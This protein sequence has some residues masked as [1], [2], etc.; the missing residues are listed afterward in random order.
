MYTYAHVHRTKYY[1]L[2][3]FMPK[4]T[5]IN[6]LNGVIQYK[7]DWS[8]TSQ[9]NSFPLRELNQ[10]IQDTSSELDICMKSV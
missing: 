9:K 4:D 2:H 3:L 10:E 6:T 8:V 5:L 1:G 7:L